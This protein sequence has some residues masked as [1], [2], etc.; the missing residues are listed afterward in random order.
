MPTAP[1]TPARYLAKEQSEESLEHHTPPHGDEDVV[2]KRQKGLQVV[3]EFGLEDKSLRNSQGKGC[4]LL[5]YKP[6]IRA[7]NTD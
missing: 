1:S 3:P 7:Q 6:Y 4:V 5:L 2:R